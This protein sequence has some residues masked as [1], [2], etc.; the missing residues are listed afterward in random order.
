MHH[1]KQSL[2]RNSCHSRLLVYVLLCKRCFITES[3]HLSASTFLYTVEKSAV[4]VCLSPVS[5]SL[6]LSLVFFEQD[7]LFYFIFLYFFFTLLYC[8]CHVQTF[9]LIVQKDN[10][11]LLYGCFFEPLNVKD[12]RSICLCIYALSRFLLLLLLPLLLP[13]SSSSK[14]SLLLSPFLLVSVRSFSL[15]L[16][17]FDVL[18]FVQT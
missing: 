8:Y 3:I 4:C 17:R 13:S 9:Y 7:L 6:L 16:C 11:V 2:N 10:F 5:L 12:G 14:Q 15:S 18:Q 1:I